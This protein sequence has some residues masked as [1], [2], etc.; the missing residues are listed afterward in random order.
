MLS[1]I[2]PSA[3]LS[4]HNIAPVVVNENVGN[5]VVRPVSTVLTSGV[6]TYPEQDPNV[7]F[8]EAA[9]NEFQTNGT[10]PLA[11]TFAGS[12]GT[13]KLPSGDALM[14]HSTVLPR[15]LFKPTLESEL[16][17]YIYLLNPQSKSKVSLNSSDPSAYPNIDLNFL[18]DPRDMDV[19]I[20]GIQCVPR[21]QFVDCF[22]P[23]A[24][25]CAAS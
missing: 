6:H 25:R 3:E 21:D 15:G 20:E 14:G 4:A 9:F 22:S 13:V 2:G 23:C 24:G 11:Q 18:S 1:G 12:Y 16:L 17:H 10:G 19:A 8:S 5:L 7:Y